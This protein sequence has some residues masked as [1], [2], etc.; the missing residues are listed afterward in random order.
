[1]KSVVIV[2][3]AVCVHGFDLLQ[4]IYKYIYYTIR[5]QSGGL[6]AKKCRRRPKHINISFK[7]VA[8]I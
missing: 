6:Y 4:K 8:E 3:R 1:M 2:A 7:N 5:S